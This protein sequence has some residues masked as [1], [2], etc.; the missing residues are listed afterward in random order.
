MIRIR[1]DDF[2]NTKDGE[3]DRHSLAAFRE[4]H[5]CLSGLIGGATYLLGVIPKRC[6]VE[7][8]LFLRNETNCVIGMHGI[9][10]DESKLD[11][12]QNEF[13][14]F[15]TANDIGSQLLRAS[16]ALDS[17]IGRRTE[18]YMPPRNRIDARTVGILQDCG[19]HAYTT[20][21]ETPAELRTTPDDG[22]PFPI[23]SEPPHE[24]G[25]TDE[26][27]ARGSHEIL[28]ARG[29]L[30]ETILTLH[31]TWETNIGL[32]HMRRFLGFFP[33]HYFGDF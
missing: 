30:H 28:L 29:A 3:K 18:I 7:D 17:G 21:P 12:Y 16:T 6:S 26:M 19:F 27:W 1:V 13:P 20:G 32:D 24:Y 5:R 4:F 11:V 14:P 23:H 8:I 31:W 10:H 33:P 2:P 9:D 25:R 15:M 22:R